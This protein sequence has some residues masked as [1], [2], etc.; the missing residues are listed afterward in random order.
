MSL[1]ILKSYPSLVVAECPRCRSMLVFNQRGRYGDNVNPGLQ[2]LLFFSQAEDGIRDHCVTG[3]QTCALPICRVTCTAGR[4][5]LRIGGDIQA[6]ETGANMNKSLL[7]ITALFVAT[8]PYAAHAQGTIRG[9]EIGR[10]S[11]RERA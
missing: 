9:A 4:M 11:C 7:T 10:A 1:D 6:N 3:V 2:C 8:L 5:P